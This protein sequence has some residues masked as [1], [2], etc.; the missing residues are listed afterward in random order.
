MCFYFIIGGGRG[1]HLY[2]WVLVELCLWWKH[3]ITWANWIPS[4]SESWTWQSN[5]IVSSQSLFTSQLVT[6]MVNTNNRVLGAANLDWL[7]GFFRMLSS[8]EE[9]LR[10][11][12]DFLGGNQGEILPHLHH[13][14][15]TSSGH[16]NPDSPLLLL[17]TSPF[18]LCRRW[19]SMQ[20]S[21]SLSSNYPFGWCLK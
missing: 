2:L 19:G 10:L 4:S 16:P 6:K 7:R 14:L 9:L 3:G 13:A 1:N 17:W 8:I 11:W 12:E 15:C 20:V 18:Y 5:K 21:P